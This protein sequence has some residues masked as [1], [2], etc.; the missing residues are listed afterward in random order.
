MYCNLKLCRLWN[1]NPF[2]NLKVSSK[3]IH[4]P[5]GKKVLE[6]APEIMDH[7][8]LCGSPVMIGRLLVQY[9]SCINITVIY[10]NMFEITKEYLHLSKESVF[11]YF[12]SSA[13]E[14]GQNLL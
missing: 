1:K 4:V 2:F 14:L 8:V 9:S 11:T 7:F 12:V 3:I 5:N 6:K 10:C 13:P